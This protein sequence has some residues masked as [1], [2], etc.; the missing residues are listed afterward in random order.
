MSAKWRTSFIKLNVLIIGDNMFSIKEEL[1][2][3][4]NSSIKYR[5]EFSDTHYDY[6]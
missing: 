6:K 3:N 1:S 2:R 4:W 5:T